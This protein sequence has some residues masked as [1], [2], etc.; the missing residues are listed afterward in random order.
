MNAKNAHDDDFE[1]LVGRTQVALTKHRDT[2]RTVA[3]QIGIT[4]P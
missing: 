4:L 2:G 3:S 1:A